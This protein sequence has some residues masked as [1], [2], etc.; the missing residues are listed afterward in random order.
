[1]FTRYI[2]VLE[3]LAKS[4]AGATVGQVQKW[5]VHLSRGQIERAMRDLI[6]EGHVRT[7]RVPYRANVMKNVY[8]IEERAV[9]YC[10]YVVKGYDATAHQKTLPL[11]VAS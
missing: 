10:E 6:A 4:P 11:A 9:E 7:E 3:V 2:A 1:M 8:H 5:N